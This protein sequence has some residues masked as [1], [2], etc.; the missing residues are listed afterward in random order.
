[1]SAPVIFVVDL[2]RK[3]ASLCYDVWHVTAVITRLSLNRFL[4]LKAEISREYE[5]ISGK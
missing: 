5:S 4:F 3:I 1:M 2:V